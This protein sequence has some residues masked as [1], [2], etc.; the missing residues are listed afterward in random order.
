ME[1]RNILIA[2]FQIT[3]WE[4]TQ[5]PGVDGDWA[6]G[7]RMAKTFTEGIEGASEGLFITS[8]QEEGQR[9]YMATERITGTL[10][11]GR[12]GSFV[13][14]HGGLEANPGS[15]FGYIVYGTGSGDLAGVAGSAVISHDDKGAYFT[16][17]LG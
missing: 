8:G 16:I 12:S 15:W 14:Q 6:N 7:A 17:V 13:V 9:A 5:L 4:E 2:R 3:N 1:D 10:P 11:D